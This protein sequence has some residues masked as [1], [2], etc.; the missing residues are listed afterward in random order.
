MSE[1]PRRTIIC[2]EHGHSLPAFVCAH[3]L[4]ALDDGIARGI[5]WS[6]SEDGCIGAYCDACDAMLEAGGGEWTRELE[7]VADL[8]VIC[9]SCFE[10][11][12]SLNQVPA[13]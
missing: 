4:L 1:P 3:L 8:K 5:L 6:R 9:E 12:L 7:A 11:V 10:R 13:R 2:D